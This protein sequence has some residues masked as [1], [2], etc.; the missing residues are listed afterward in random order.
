MRRSGKSDLGAGAPFQRKF[1]FQN[2][3]TKNSFPCKKLIG[4]IEGTLLIAIGAM[5]VKIS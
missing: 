2:L 5:C 1:P 3:K 4:I